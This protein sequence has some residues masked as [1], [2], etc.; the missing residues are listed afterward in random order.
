MELSRETGQEAVKVGVAKAGDLI[1]NPIRV[2]AIASAENDGTSTLKC[3]RSFAVLQDA[4]M[5]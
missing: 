5:E 4:A 1:N 3:L 2:E